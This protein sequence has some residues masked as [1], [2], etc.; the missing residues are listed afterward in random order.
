MTQRNPIHAP[1]L[2]ACVF[3]SPLVALAQDATSTSN[4]PTQSISATETNTTLNGGT[5]Y[6]WIPF[7]THGYVG[8][9]VGESNFDIDCASGFSCDR[10][11]TGFKVFTGGRFHDVIGLELSF[12]N[13]VMPT[14]PAAQLMLEAPI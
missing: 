12:W 10:K 3:S 13:W 9:S 6:S 5:R 4:A 2:L 11:A 1:I 8:A 7:T 14:V